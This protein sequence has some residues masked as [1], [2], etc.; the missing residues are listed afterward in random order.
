MQLSA[1]IQILNNLNAGQSLDVISFN[2]WQVLIALINLLLLFLII[3]KFLYRPVKRT[4]KKRQEEIDSQYKQ[5]QTANEEA[6]TAKQEWELQLESAQSQANDILEQATEQ[7]N[8]RSEKIVSDA[9]EKA[10]GIISRAET[11]AQLEKKKA[12]AQIKEQ[13]V[14]VST[15][16]TEKMLER[17]INAK[18]HSRLIDSAID[19]IGS[20]N[21]KDK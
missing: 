1:K 18:D 20:D 2:I 15:A 8:V 7:A 14:A 3:K 21:E 16:L 10:I 19:T 5:A 4:L 6:Q 17:E 12:Q 13:I 11:E 9:K